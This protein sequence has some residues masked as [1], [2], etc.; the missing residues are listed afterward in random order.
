MVNICVVYRANC[1]LGL[2]PR[3]GSAEPQTSRSSRRRASPARLRRSGSLDLDPDIFKTTILT[4]TDAG[5]EAVAHLSQLSIPSK[6]SRTNQGIIKRR[7]TFPPRCLT[8]APKGRMLSRNAS[9]ERTFSLPSNPTPSPCSSFLLP[10]YPLAALPGG[11]LTPTLSRRCA[12]PSLS[13]S[14]TWPNKKESG[15]HRRDA[16][17]WSDTAGTAKGKEGRG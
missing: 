10:S 17:P 4:D 6:R 5:M 2:S 15:P 13:M 8:V 1:S 9:V 7:D 11:I 12:D 3:L 14:N 16:G